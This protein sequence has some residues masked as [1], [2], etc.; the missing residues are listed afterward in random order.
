MG[1]LAREKVQ[2]LAVDKRQFWAERLARG[3]GACPA[4]IPAQRP[5]RLPVERIVIAHLH[6]EPSPAFPILC[7]AGG[8]GNGK[9]ASC[10][11]LSLNGS[12]AGPKS[13]TGFCRE[14]ECERWPG[15]SPGPQLS[16]RR[17]AAILVLAA[18]RRV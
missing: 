3:T 18:H 2:W 16:A 5:C 7:A 17:S 14:K 8:S 13:G 12:F 4:T 9:R 6:V 11:N 1:L 10:R 15:R